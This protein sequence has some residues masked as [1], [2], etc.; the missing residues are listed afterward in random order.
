MESETI[1][2]EGE[3]V[4]RWLVEREAAKENVEKGASADK[5]GASRETSHIEGEG[6]P[7]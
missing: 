6:P 5:E 4:I 3:E 1:Y 2:Q 7:S